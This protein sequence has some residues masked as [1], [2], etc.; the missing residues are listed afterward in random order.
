MDDNHHPVLITKNNFGLLTF[1]QLHYDYLANFSLRLRDDFQSASLACSHLTR[2]ADNYSRFTRSLHCL[3]VFGII[4]CA[5]YA[6]IQFDRQQSWRRTPALNR[7]LLMQIM[8]C[9]NP[10]Y[11]EDNYFMPTSHLT[12]DSLPQT[13]DSQIISA[14]SL[15]LSLPQPPKRFFRHGWQSWALTTWL[16]PSDPPI[17]VRAAEFRVKD[18]DPAIRLLEKPHQRLGRC[19]GTWTMTI[20]SCSARWTWADALNWMA[21][22]SKVFTKMDMTSQWLVMRGREDEV[23]AKYVD[24]LERKFGKGRFEKAPRVWCSWYSLYGWINERVILKAL[25]DF[26]D[27]PFDVFQLDDG[28]QLAHG[29]WEANKKVS[30]RYESPR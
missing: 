10:P 15:R 18:E 21:Q 5:D 2:L 20:F 27:M 16:D 3:S 17:P 1:S 11:L 28:W 4:A 13:F 25:N 9:C 19:G 14:S 12:L 29:D 23:F 30:I 7:D 26:G 24:L 8:Q 6:T 22:R